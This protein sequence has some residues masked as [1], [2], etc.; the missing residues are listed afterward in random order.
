MG[1]IPLF[2]AI[3]VKWD[4]HVWRC[5]PTNWPLIKPMMKHAFPS[6]HVRDHDNSNRV[7]HFFM[8]ES[9][10]FHSMGYPTIKNMDRVQL[11]HSTCSGRHALSCMHVLFIFG[12]V[13]LSSA[14][15]FWEANTLSY[16]ITPRCKYQPWTL[17]LKTVTINHRHK[18][19]R[20]IS[21]ILV[22]F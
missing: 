15:S 4:W 2:E 8:S 19:N 9:V 21:Y 14:I 13:S 6:A 3:S 16:L 11:S 1:D 12:I 5:S 22:G 18:G 20:S 7:T 17:A 10:W